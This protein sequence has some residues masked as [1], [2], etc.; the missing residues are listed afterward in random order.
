MSSFET[1]KRVSH[2]ECF[3]YPQIPD[4]GSRSLR[5]IWSIQSSR[6]L[7]PEQHATSSSRTTL[8]TRG[9]LSVLCAVSFANFFCR[10]VSCS[11]KRFSNNSKWMEKF[12]RAH[13]MNFGTPLSAP[14]KTRTQAKSYVFLMQLTNAKIAEGPSL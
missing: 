6:V 12:S 11:P 10:N 14:Q 5:N 9:V 8:R 2:Q 13:L 3:G 4:V 7:N 1:G